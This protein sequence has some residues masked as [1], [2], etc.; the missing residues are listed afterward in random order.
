MQISEKDDRMEVH[1]GAEYT[2]AEVQPACPAGFMEVDVAHGD[3]RSTIQIRRGADERTFK[4]LLEMRLNLKPGCYIVR[5][6]RGEAFDLTQEVH[7]VSGVYTFIVKRGSAQMTVLGCPTTMEDD[8][9]QQALAHWGL[10]DEDWEL[11]W[12]D[13]PFEAQDRMNT[14]LV[15]RSGDDTVEV[16][17]VTAESE[18]PA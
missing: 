9:K 7:V 13:G 18:K 8:I 15:P 17:F 12:S 4:N 14:E 5:Y 6:G 16:V 10:E 1:L 11:R 2:A 3:T